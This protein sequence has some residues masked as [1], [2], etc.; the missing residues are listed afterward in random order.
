V[1]GEGDKE[2]EEVETPNI[3]WSTALDSDCARYR[4]VGNGVGASEGGNE[5]LGSSSRCSLLRQAA[6]QQI[7]RQEGHFQMEPELPGWGSSR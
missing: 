6:Q 1:L 2:G 7:L 5:P 3:S 4:G